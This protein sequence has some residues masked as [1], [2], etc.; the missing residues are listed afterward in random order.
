MMMLFDD[1]YDDDGGVANR[2]NKNVREWWIIKEK[3]C[4]GGNGV[5]IIMIIIK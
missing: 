3:D 2:G 1:V 5:V 4:D